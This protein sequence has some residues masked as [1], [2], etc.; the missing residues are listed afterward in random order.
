MEDVALDYN[1]V[2]RRFEVV[3]SVREEMRV[4]LWSIDPQDWE[5]AEWRFE[6]NLFAHRQADQSFYAT[7]DGFHPTGAV[8]DPRAGVQYI[9]IYSGHPCG[10]A[11]SFMIKRTLD[12]PSLAHFLRGRDR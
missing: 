7:A 3:R 9:F 2:T 6:G 4:E 10:P 12:T 8:V 5:S 1:P 11:G